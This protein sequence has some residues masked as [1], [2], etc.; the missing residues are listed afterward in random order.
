MSTT[1]IARAEQ[2]AIRPL[3]M[4]LNTDSA[5]FL[6]AVE[7]AYLAWAQGMYGPGVITS[8]DGGSVLGDRVAEQSS[9]SDLLAA[10]AENLN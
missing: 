1:T 9:I 10:R 5:H 4:G 8:K 2:S 6:A 3:E 7:A